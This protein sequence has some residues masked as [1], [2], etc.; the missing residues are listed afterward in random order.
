MASLR[1][2]VEPAA[3]AGDSV[4]AGRLLRSPLAVV[5]LTVFIDLLGF[6]IILPLLPFYAEH[7]GATGAWVGA[8]LTAYS[9]VQFVSAPFL[10]R[11][12]DRVGRRPVL[13]LSLAGSAASLALT[14]AA[15]S[16]WLL[17][18][19]RALAG[20][21]GGSISTAQAY[22]ADVTAPRERAKYMGMLG[23]SIGL[24]FVFGP[25][26]GA[27]F[28][29]FGFGAAAFFAAGLAA[30][31][32]AFAYFKLPES[33]PRGEGLA[34]HA[35]VARAKF[36]AVLRRPAIARIVASMFL[37]T[38]AF[39]GLEATLALFG[40]H[41]FGLGAA[42]FGLIF[43]YLGVVGVAV[44]GGLVGR[45]SRRYGERTLATL[46]AVLMG[47]AF[48]ALAVAPDLL[49]AIVALS[50][51]GVGQGFVSPTLSTLLSRAGH[52][53]QQGSTL[54]IGQS[55]NAAARAIGP[56]VAGGL[57]DLNRAV[58]YLAGACLVLIA[59]V[60][61]SQLASGVDLVA[62]GDPTFR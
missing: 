6:S 2:S 35:P 38:F 20:L 9:A 19:G 14:G 26:I 39:V 4:R 3:I 37:A 45:L 50:A 32:L 46:G 23:A 1:E 13:L 51:L 31:N 22:V 59:A 33:R 57:Y 55:S 15:H 17:L 27:G 43:T 5:Y 42:G 7:Y 11:L 18:A 25:A 53:E 47:I 24:G 62:A 49:L 60:L 16:L 28:S 8:L 30:V 52:A 48:A 61:L 44:Q 21:F 10:G 36:G 40:Q 56:I 34:G 12:S 58:P 29:R 54:G 41:R